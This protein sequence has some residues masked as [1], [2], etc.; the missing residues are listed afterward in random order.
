MASQKKVNRLARDPK[1]QRFRD[2]CMELLPL[3]AFNPPLSASD[4]EK[5][6]ERIRR[7][8]EEFKAE[9]RRRW[10]LTLETKFGGGRHPNALRGFIEENLLDVVV[11]ETKPPRTRL[12]VVLERLRAAAKRGGTV[13]REVIPPK[14]DPKGKGYVG[15]WK[16]RRKN[17]SGEIEWSEPETTPYSALGKLLDRIRDAHSG[18]RTN[19]RSTEEA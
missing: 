11:D 8:F 3:S 4:L 18:K 5:H 14:D 2:A 10:L 6:E 1:Y 13:I 9:R 12:A 17:A 7:D 15:W 16:R 19:R